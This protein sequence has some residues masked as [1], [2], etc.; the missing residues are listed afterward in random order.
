MPLGH[1]RSVRDWQA[2]VRALR[3]VGYDDVI[4][5]ENEDY[6][7]SAEEAIRT[8]AATLSFCIDHP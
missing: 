7:L 3:E 8:S 6:T 1:G 5:I 4:S 2:I